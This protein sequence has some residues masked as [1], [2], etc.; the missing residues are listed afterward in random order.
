MADEYRTIIPPV[1][2][3]FDRATIYRDHMIVTYKLKDA[4]GNTHGER[5]VTVKA[6]AQDPVHAAFAAALEALSEQTKK[7]VIK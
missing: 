1:R 3:S 7:Q 6:D 5:A 4:E 2:P